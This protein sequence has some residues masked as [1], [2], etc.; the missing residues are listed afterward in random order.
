MK[1][2]SLNNKKQKLY[3]KTSGICRTENI[4]T[5]VKKKKNTFTG[6]AQQQNVDDGGNGQQKLTD[7]NNSTKIEKKMYRDSGTSGAMPRA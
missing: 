1:R 6:Q 7:L 4:I 5:Q 3:R 2:Q